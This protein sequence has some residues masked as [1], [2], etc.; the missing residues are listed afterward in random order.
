MLLSH[1]PLPGGNIM[2]WAP[3]TERRAHIINALSAAQPGVYTQEDPHL[4][5]EVT[6]AY[7]HA[8]RQHLLFAGF[9][10][11]QYVTLRS[12]LEPIAVSLGSSW[13]GQQYACDEHVT[14]AERL[15]EATFTQFIARSCE[16]NCQRHITCVVY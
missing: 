7:V 13:D 8:L 1:Q 10:N 14:R 6:A 2:A 11:V 5:E 16:P 15:I 3:S 12:L 9:R 4:K